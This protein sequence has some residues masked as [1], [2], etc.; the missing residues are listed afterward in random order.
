MAHLAH[1]V[2]ECEAIMNTGVTWLMTNGLE[3][4]RNYAML[5]PLT[6]VALVVLVAVLFFELGRV[7]KRLSPARPDRSLGGSLTASNGRTTAQQSSDLLLS[8]CRR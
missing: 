7:V 4:L 5:A 2:G 1:N 6:L 8:D 3:A